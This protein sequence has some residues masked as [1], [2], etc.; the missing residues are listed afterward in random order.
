MAA[1]TDAE[2][3]TEVK[4]A[5]GITGNYQDAT[6]NI[7]IGDVK[8][9]MKAAGVKPLVLNST[10]AIGAICRGVSDI[11]NYGAGTEFSTYFTQRVIQLVYTEPEESGAV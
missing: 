11:W 5:L 6:L 8:E 2:I 9:Y 3:L 10:A 1:M 7:Y 4:N